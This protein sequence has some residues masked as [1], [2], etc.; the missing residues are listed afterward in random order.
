MEFR[1]DLNGLRAVGV[2]AVVMFHYGFSHF[3]GGFVGVDIFFV[4][5]GFL[6]ASIVRAQLQQRR[7]S[8]TQFLLNRMRRILPA[9]AVLV[10]A[11]FVW[12][13][14]STCLTTTAGS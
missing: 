3:G 9:L 8:A 13:G 5:S 14:F 7:F 1:K 2:A 4:I 12:T 11:C 10:L 6:L